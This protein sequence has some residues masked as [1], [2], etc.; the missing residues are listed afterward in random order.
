[1]DNIQQVCHLARL[2]YELRQRIL[3]HALKH[4]GTIGLQTPIW[5]DGSTFQQPL[6]AVSR[7]IRD[8]ALEAFY[9]INTFLWH[10][11][12]PTPG[13][14]ARGDSDPVK[15]PLPA[16]INLLLTP[17]LPWHYPTLMKDLRYLVINV[18]LPSDTDP[19]T[20]SKSFAQQ[21]R[22]LVAALDAGKR[23]NTLR[24]TF[25]TGPWRQSEALPTPLMEAL[26][27]LADLRCQEGVI[28][29][30]RPGPSQIADDIYSL[31]LGRK[32]T[33]EN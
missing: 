16:D 30:V 29:R 19:A 9:K 11:H 1:M 13:N 5:D 21:L 17:S 28:V 32:P 10:V 25:I 3:K 4:P 15:Y 33:I 8:E 31:G 12:R 7:S 22:S 6:F 27:V 23:L 26:R 18:F 2:P 14:G 24:L 20:W